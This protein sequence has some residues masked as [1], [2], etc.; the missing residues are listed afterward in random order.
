MVSNT[1][2][3]LLARLF[4]PSKHHF[5]SVGTLN[6]AALDRW[7]SDHKSL[8][9]SD[10]FTP[11]HLAD[12]YVTLPTRDGT[13]GLRPYEPP[14]EG[15]PLAYG[16][17]LAFFHP[18]NPETALCPDGTDG[19][20]CPPEP[21]TRRMWAG[22]TMQWNTNPA[23]ILRVGEK[24]RAVS[25][26]ASVEKK[27]F[28]PDDEGA[29]AKPMVFVTQRVEITPEGRSRPS[30]IEER[31]HVYLASSGGKRTVR[32]V[33]GQPKPDFSFSY[34]PSLITLFRFSALT[35]NGHHI[36]LDKDY[37]QNTEGYPE[38]LVHGPLT[39]LM[40]LEVLLFHCP[41]L[42]LHAF[43]YR[44]RN[45]VIVNR[46]CTIHGSF[47]GENQADVWCEDAA[48]VVGMTGNISFA[49]KGVL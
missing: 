11:T 1:L 6:I 22:G 14:E 16:H 23:C 21:F 17:H 15:T 38:R 19:E 24:A 5:R 30:V 49:S 20:F 42:Q 45:P 41:G 13:H 48:G 43:N 33:H 46:T 8:T 10:T 18:R 32:Q 35:F 47:T 9:L 7:I 4:P 27:G 12:L 36:H 39:A 37:A 40:L 25:N 28:G 26:V 34:K 44:A 2:V 29:N 3:Q 31:S